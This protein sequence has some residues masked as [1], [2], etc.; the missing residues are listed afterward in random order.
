MTSLAL[1]RLKLGALTTFV[2]VAIGFVVYLQHIMLRDIN[3]LT[4]WLLVAAVLMLAAY[5][6]RK[7]LYFLP[8]GTSTAWM[9]LHAYVGLLTVAL[10]FMHVGLEFPSG[11]LEVVR[12][13]LA[14]EA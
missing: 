1:R 6:A 13:P 11:R 10:F 14:S 5:N 7:K 9:R 4:G 8:L 2:A 3:F 12:Q